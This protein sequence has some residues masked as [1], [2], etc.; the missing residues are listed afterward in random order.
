MNQH[1]LDSCEH[2]QE[3]MHFLGDAEGETHA[4]AVQAH[5]SHCEACQQQWQALNGLLESL[6]SAEAP[7]MRSAFADEAF[8]RVREQQTRQT[9]RPAWYGQGAMAM[10]ASFMLVAVFVFLYNP[11]PESDAVDAEAQVQFTSADPQIDNAPES[12]KLR[13]AFNSPGSAKNVGIK[14]ELPEG[15]GLE[16]RN[17]T[18]LSWEIDLVEGKNELQLPLVKLAGGELSAADQVVTAEL[19]H[20]DQVKAFRVRLVRAGQVG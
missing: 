8:V 13:L 19:R 12:Y 16:G 10:A 15:I 6:A 7:P 4:E 11:T 3:I 17:D 5:I 20:G 2:I 14:I 9:R 18:V 1:N